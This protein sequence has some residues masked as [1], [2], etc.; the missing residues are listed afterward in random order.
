M[1]LALGWVGI[2]AWRSDW[3][4]LAGWLWDGVGCIWRTDGVDTFWDL[5]VAKILAS[6]GALWDLACLVERQSLGRFGTRLVQP[7]LLGTER[8]VAG[9]GTGFR[10]K[11]ELMAGLGRRTGLAAAI[12]WFGT[13]GDHP[14][15]AECLAGFGTV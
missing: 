2:P 9:L 8:L 12:S 6:C 10:L 1:W 11:A 5:G 3:L 14:A 13:D 4:A 15:L 7:L